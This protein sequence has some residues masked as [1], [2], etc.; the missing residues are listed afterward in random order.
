[1]VKS[2]KNYLE[3]MLEEYGK[4]LIRAD[5]AWSALNEPL[6][7][8]FRDDPDRKKPTH[9]LILEVFIMKKMSMKQRFMTE[10]EAYGKMLLRADRAW[11]E[12]RST[13]LQ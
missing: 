13:L 10:W 3:N 1:M 6:S 7:V 11:A 12:R 8:P 5:R 4:M 2:V 9:H